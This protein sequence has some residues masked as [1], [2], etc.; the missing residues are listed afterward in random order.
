MKA[1]VEDDGSSD[2]DTPEQPEASPA[3]PPGLAAENETGRVHV[4]K[5]QS[6]NDQAR[7]TQGT[8]S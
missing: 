8:K 5:S 1:W 6:A 4:T 3:V 2:E 7:R